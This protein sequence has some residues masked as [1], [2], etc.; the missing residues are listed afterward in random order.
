MAGLCTLR[1]GGG[2]V[3]RGSRM[4]TRA[5]FARG[6]LIL[7]FRFFFFLCSTGAALVLMANAVAVGR[8]LSGR[9]R[10]RSEPVLEGGREGKSDGG[11][12]TG[13]CR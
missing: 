13:R 10:H 7:P 5:W 6:M 1:A 12:V 11:R 8:L 9:G 3:A 4:L 2:S